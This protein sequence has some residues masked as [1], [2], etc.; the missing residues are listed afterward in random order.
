LNSR[1]SNIRTKMAVVRLLR[2]KWAERDEKGPETPQAQRARTLAALAQQLLGLAARQ[3]VLVVVEDAHWIDPTTL[4]MIEEGLDRIAAARVLLLLTSRPDR[5]PALAAHPHVTRL[6]LNRLG[7]AGVEAIVA[8]LG[9]ERLPT[10]TI[11][12][13]IARTDGVPL[14]VEELTK[15][16]LE[17]GETAIP[18][19]LH[20]S[21][22]AR[23]DRIPEVKEVAQI[24]AS[25]GRE[26]DYPLLAAVV[27]RSEPDLRSALDKLA[28]SELIFRRGRPPDARYTFK[29]S[30]VQDAAYDSLLKNRRR[31]VHA[32]IATAL[33]AREATGAETSPVELAHHHLLADAPERAL[34]PL[35]RAAERAAAVGAI[36]EALVHYRKA[37]ELLAHLPDQNARRALEADLFLGLG[38]QTQLHRGAGSAEPQ[39]MF[40]RALELATEQ[41]SGRTRFSAAWNLWRVHN[42]RADFEKA[43]AAA[44]SL[45]LIGR[46]TGETELVLQTHHA[47]WWT[48]DCVGEIQAALDHVEQ[49]RRAV[50]HVPDGHASLFGGHDALVCGAGMAAKAH[51]LM[52]HMADAER[53]IGAC[54]SRAERLGD[55]ATL[56]NAL[57]NA[58]TFGLLR[59]DHDFLSPLFE[60]LLELG[61]PE[62][63]QDF[64]AFGCFARGWVAA[65]SGGAGEGETDMRTAIALAEAA[66]RMFDA[67]FWQALLA[68]TLA[69]AGRLAEAEEAC[70]KALEQITRTSAGTIPESEVRRIR[71]HLAFR[72]G[73]V[74]ESVQHLE[75][76][77][78]LARRSGSRLLELRAATSLAR[79]RFQQGERQKAHDLL[80]PVY[81]W[82]TEG[83]ETPDLKDAKALLDELA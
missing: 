15:A 1:A 50:A 22:M 20:D 75:R 38:I 34:E 39:A 16:V 61:E 68:E 83:F 37:L 70:S 3:P 10:A 44:S 71:G 14:F 35:R 46:D 47:N 29:H 78:A 36:T 6:T 4:E 42:T 7:R 55:R 25:I 49:A 73:R 43:R 80:A 32:R 52:G 59:R 53:E 63:L 58:I 56:G 48:L 77:I 30:L 57:D 33:E 74:A 54:L 21:L 79:I 40:E 64:V 13:I 31:A 67:P 28:A 2:R 69:D 76:A 51:L 19:S 24:A 82:F 81:D 9:G 60:R 45:T 11:D 17:T 62:G 27:D 65:R 72:Y 26:F 66:G 41:G 12:T 8:R 5:Q 23:L 18:A